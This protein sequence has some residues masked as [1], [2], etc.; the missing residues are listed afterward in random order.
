[1]RFVP[2]HKGVAPCR[3]ARF[4]EA[5]WSNSAWTMARWPRV[6]GIPGPGDNQWCRAPAPPK[7]RLKKRHRAIWKW[8]VGPNYVSFHMISIFLDAIRLKPSDETSKGRYQLCAQLVQGNFDSSFQNWI[9][10][11]KITWMVQ[12][13]TILRPLSLNNGRLPK[14]NKTRQLTVTGL[15][16]FCRVMVPWWQTNPGVSPLWKPVIL[17][18]EITI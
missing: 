7:W 14:Q 15:W 12:K 11:F 4:G 3:S 1:M 13:K 8:D 5:L 18:N 16:V 2:G 10:E 17:T 9:A 6:P